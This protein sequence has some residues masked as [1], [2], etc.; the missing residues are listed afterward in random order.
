[1]ICTQ[2][3]PGR[4]ARWLG[5]ALVV[6]TLIGSGA[7]QAQGGA[8]KIIARVNGD[9][10]ME[11]EFYDRLQRL[12]AQDFLVSVN[13]LQL[14]SE[15]AGQLTLETL[16]TERLILQWAAKTQQ[17]PSDADVNGQLA[18]LEKQPNIAQA[19][20]NK[21][22][23]EDMMR[24]SIRVQRARFN[25]ATTAAAVSPPEVED[26]Y[27]KHIAQFT[28]PERWG[29]ADI[30]ISKSDVVDKAEADLK[31]GKSFPDVAKAYSDDARTK[32]NGGTMGLV[33]AADPSLPA[34]MKEAIKLLKVGEVTPPL[35]LEVRDMQ[36]KPATIWFILRLTSK[37]PESVRSFAEVKEQVEQEALLEK[38]G[39][40][41]V[42]DKKIQ[43]FRQQ[44]DIQV[45]L[46]G[47]QSLAST[48]KKS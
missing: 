48:P 46:P 42:A 15:T 35:K 32:D 11:S 14:R 12:R 27:K 43:Q 36:G 45:S 10:I 6:G 1:M 4:I 2:H 5:A 41:Q 34:P 47:Y 7:A 21:L 19:L 13:P 33:A 18:A 28:T 20:A 16:I 29:L 9:S 3:S 23:S 25:L 44:S 31:A 17:M 37:E 8:D 38:A 22:I 40:Y 30:R 26:Y 24:N 39:G